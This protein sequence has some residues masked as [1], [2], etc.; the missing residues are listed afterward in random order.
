[1]HIEYW[2]LDEW[3]ERLMLKSQQPWVP[4]LH[5]RTR[6]ILGAADEAVV[7]KVHLKP[8]KIRRKDQLFTLVEN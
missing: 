6:E 4:S 5:P 7:K 2:M 3:L 8:Q 1:M